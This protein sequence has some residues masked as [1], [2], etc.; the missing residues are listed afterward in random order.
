MD[1]KTE[2]LT[3][4]PDKLPRKKEYDITVNHAPI[5]ENILSTDERKLALKN[6][7]RYFDKKHHKKLIPE[8]NSELLKF[9]RIYMYR[10]FHTFLILL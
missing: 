1:F 4:I 5:R 8:F 6:A 2:I 10:F 7:L 9:G 3:G